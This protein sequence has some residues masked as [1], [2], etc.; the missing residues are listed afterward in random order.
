MGIREV[1]QRKGMYTD[2]SNSA[3]ALLDSLVTH[4]A[5]HPWHI[6]HN[7]GR[8]VSP[9]PL[10][11]CDLTAG[12]LLCRSVLA[13]EAEARISRQC[14]GGDESDAQSMGLAASSRSLLCSLKQ[15]I[16]CGGL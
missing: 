12:L 7:Y 3:L 4:R 5:L 10:R 1:G 9:P 14:A 13:V 16:W 8:S 15:T 11:P 2:D 6:A